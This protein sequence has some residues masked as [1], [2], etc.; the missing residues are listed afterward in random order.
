ML[1]K[2]LSSFGFTKD[3]IFTTNAG[4]RSRDYTKERPV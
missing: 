3:G 1:R 4:Y 2:S